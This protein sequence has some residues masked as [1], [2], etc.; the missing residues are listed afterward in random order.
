MQRYLARRLLLF[1]PTLLL[2]SLA[3]FT[4]MRVLPGDVASVIAGG[5]DAGVI[6]RQILEGIRED[7]GL[8]DP[9]PV[10]YGNWLWT[11]VN[12]QFGGV[13]FT[14]K[15]SLR[16]IL[17]RR[18]PVTVQLAT[19]SILLSLLISVPLGVTAAVYQNRWPDY[20]IRA[21]T[22]AGHALPNF[23]VALMFLGVAVIFFRWSPPVFYAHLWTDP[24]LHMERM[25]WPALILAWGYSAYLIRMT[26]SN[27]LEVLGQDYIRMA[28]SK[29]LSSKVVLSRHALRN[30][31][32]PV[33]T[34]SGIQLGSLLGGT[35][36][37]ELIFALPGI[38]QG[39]V[40]AATERDYPV[41]Q[42]LVTWMVFFMLTINLFVDIIY[43][44][45]D[46]RI[47]YS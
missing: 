4:I 34:L 18:M 38:G 40:I 24:V 10:Q 46:P 23:W 33:V 1:V 44:W 6:D 45:M 41:I 17:A 19:Y 37:L 8:K 16:S 27:L 15:E 29:G 22:G 36:T 14:E 3:V 5:G 9:L 42:S 43:A 21:T 2:A 20:L 39:I 35:V 31:L 30:A 28:R 7:F 32:I 47:K 12:G 25:I 11:M 13:S 26:R